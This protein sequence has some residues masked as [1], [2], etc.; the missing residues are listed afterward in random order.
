MKRRR[1]SVCAPHQEGLISSKLLYI[2]QYS[3]VELGRVPPPPPMLSSSQTYDEGF[4]G[5]YPQKK[6][7]LHVS[8]WRLARPKWKI[9]GWDCW[10]GFEADPLW[11]S[12]EAGARETRTNFSATEHTVAVSQTKQDRSIYPRTHQQ[13]LSAHQQPPYPC[14]SHYEKHL[15]IIHVVVIRW[16]LVVPGCIWRHSNLRRSTRC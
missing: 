8:P 13:A 2:K 7:K 9:A 1:E 4:C 5:P 10:R 3:D 15:N 11:V 12:T 14:S 16:R 6:N